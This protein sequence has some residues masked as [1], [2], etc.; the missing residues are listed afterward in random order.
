MRSL[1]PRAVRLATP[2]LLPLL[3]HQGR[4][5]QRDMPRLPRATGTTGT[6]DTSGAAD[7]EPLRLLVLGDSIA[8]SVGA[9]HNSQGLAGQLADE[10]ARL[11]ARPVAW[12]V[13]ARPGATAEWATR[14]LAPDAG[15]GEE[16]PDLVVV[17]VGVNDLLAFRTPT[18]WRNGVRA[19]AH[20]IRTAVAGPGGP[21]EPGEVLPLVFVGLPPVGRLPALPQPLRAALG[22]RGVRLDRELARVARELGA[23]H[24]PGPALPDDGEGD[25]DGDGILAED[26][27]HPT[28]RGYGLLVRELAPVVAAHTP[29]AARTGVS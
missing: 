28:E 23:H 8:A 24:V 14:R 18:R 1:S 26:R 9:T 2:L 13:L 6:S 17:S 16:P 5:V 21:G 10:V 4:K 15:A 27:F 11:A 3:A 22:A 20:A 25:G 19:L 7:E 29:D 12:R